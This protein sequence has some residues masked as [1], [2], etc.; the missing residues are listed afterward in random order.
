MGVL[1]GILFKIE[2]Y[3]II[4]LVRIVCPRCVPTV[5]GCCVQCG[6]SSLSGKDLIFFVKLPQLVRELCLR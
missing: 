6:R 5:P 3:L 4:N 1:E 2:C